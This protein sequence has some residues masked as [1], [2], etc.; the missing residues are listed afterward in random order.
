MGKPPFGGMTQ[1]QVGDL[2][3]GYYL[4][5]GGD[6]TAGYYPGQ[7]GGVTSGYPGWGVIRPARRQQ[8]PL[9]VRTPFNLTDADSALAKCV[10]MAPPHSLPKILPPL[11]SPAQ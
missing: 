4:R 8:G 6:R 9:V 11:P 7:G 1:S 3:A 2:T 10:F 5:C